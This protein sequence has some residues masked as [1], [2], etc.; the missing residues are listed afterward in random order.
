MATTKSNN[1][2]L[3]AGFVSVF[4]RVEMIERIDD[5]LCCV[6]MLTHRSLAEI[7]EQAFKF[8]LPRTGPAW[9]FNDMIAKL[10]YQYGLVCGDYKDVDSLSGMPDVAILM[11]D[12]NHETDI[13]R[14]VVWHHVRGTP[15]QA[16]FHYVID[17]LAELDP[18][19]RCTTDFKHLQ[20]EAPI[21]YLEVTPRP[22]TAM[23]RKGK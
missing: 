6:A 14:H 10:L 22:D 9:V 8:G 3:P 23:A 2:A 17:P 18:K 4:K 20:I 19:H 7:K 12:Y 1:G 13:G 16:A 21:Y 5:S 15:E 11:V